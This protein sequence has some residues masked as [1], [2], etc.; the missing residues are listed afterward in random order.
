MSHDLAKHFS[1]TTF[2]VLKTQLLLICRGILLA[3]EHKNLIFE[4]ETHCQNNWYRKICTGTVTVFRVA[5][6]ETPEVAL[7]IGLLW[8]RLQLS[9]VKYHKQKIYKI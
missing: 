3:G 1:G 7:Q 4:S 9:P 2:I 5:E 6:L 8:L